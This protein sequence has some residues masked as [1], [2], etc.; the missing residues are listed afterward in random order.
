[1]AVVFVVFAALGGVAAALWMRHEPKAEALTLPR[2]ARVRRVDGEVGLNRRPDA[3]DPEAQWVELTPN[4]PLTDG[5]RLY[6][7]ED[8]RAS[9][10]FTGRNFARLEPDSALDVVSL[11]DRRTQLALR[12]GSAIFD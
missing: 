12:E 7:R 6:V 10:D 9:I 8:S 1:M 3:E 4:T 2:A 5:D 11:S